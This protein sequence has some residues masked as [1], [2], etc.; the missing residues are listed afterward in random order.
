[1]RDEDERGGVFLAREPIEKTQKIFASDGIE[2]GARLVENQKARAGHEGARDE[3]ALTFALGE[4]LPLAVDEA[5]GAERAETFFRRDDVGA[6]GREPEIELGVAAADDRFEGRFGGGHAGLEGAGDDADLE[7]KLAPIGFAIALAEERDVAGTGREVAEERFEERG[8]AAAIA[9]ENHPVFAA[10]DAPIEAVKN[11]VVAAGDA[12]AR[13]CEN[14][15][16]GR[17]T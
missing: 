13:D 5:G 9:A 4:E 14:R 1:M 7:A 16:H 11:D 15:G 2:A 8:L 12:E 10:P 17:A 6:R 3:D